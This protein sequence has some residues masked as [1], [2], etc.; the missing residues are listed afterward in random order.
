M[1]FQVFVEESEERQF[2]KPERIFRY[3]TAPAMAW[4]K[5]HTWVVLGIRTWKNSQHT[6]LETNQAFNRSGYAK[7][8]P[9]IFS[10]IG[11]GPE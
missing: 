4:R 6:P 1:F 11:K 8:F 10:K 2:F 7:V 9:N 3:R 5:R